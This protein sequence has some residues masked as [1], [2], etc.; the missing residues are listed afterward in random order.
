M[1]GLASDS[2][3]MWGVG[4]AL[5]DFVELVVAFP[6]ALSRFVVVQ[7]GWLSDGLQL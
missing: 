4:E 1:S 7:S 2:T 6:A 3:S 5:L